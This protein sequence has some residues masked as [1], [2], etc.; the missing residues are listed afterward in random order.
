[1]KKRFSVILYSILLLA[2]ATV[3][4]MT[5]CSQL[6]LAAPENVTYN[7]TTISWNAVENA[8]SYTVRINEGD[9]Y[10][11]TEPRYPY[12]ASG[13]EFSVTITAVSDASKIIKSGETKLTFRPLDSIGDIRFSEDGSAAWDVVNLA[14]GYLVKIDGVVINKVIATPAYSEI[15]A[16][17]HSIQVRPV[18]T[19]DNSYYSAWSDAKSITILDTLTK[20]DISYSEGFIKWKY[21]TGAFC[22]EVSVNGNVLTSD[23]RATQ[24]AYDHENNDFEVRIKAIGNRTTTYDGKVSESKAFVFL[25]TVT[26]IFVEDG[27]LNWNEISGA[28]GYKLKLNGT[29]YTSILRENSFDKLTANVTTDIQILPIS[30]DTTYFSDWSAVKSV[31]LLPAP[32]LQWNSDYELDGAANSNVYWNGGGSAS[33]YAV[34]LT[35]PDGTVKITTYGNTQRYF[36]DAYSQVGTYTVEVKALASTTDTN[37]YDSV[38]SMPITVTRLAA[39]KAAG[40]NFIVSNPASVSEGFTV[41]FAKVSGATQYRLYKDDS[42]SQTSNTNQFVVSDVVR[43]DIIEEQ[44]INYKIQSVGTVNTVNGKITATL[45]SLSSESL[46][47][48]ISV[49]A[50]PAN[51]TMSGYTYTY[52]AVDRNQ[53]YVV[54]VGGQSYSG[55]GTSYDLSVLE[56]GIYSVSV[57]AK[58]NGSNILASNYT[59]AISVCRLDA[60]ANVKIETSDASEGILTYDDVDNAKGYYIVF[61]NDGNAIPVT[62][63][64]NINQYITEK[65]TTVYMQSSANYFNDN[66]T[67]Y[68]MTSRPGATVNF[69]KLAQPT[70]GDV[71]FTDTQLIWRHSDNINT[72]VYT[73]TY[74]VYYAN[75]TV[76]NGEKNGTTLDISQLEGGRSYTFYVKAIGNSTNYINSALS[77]PVTIYKL[78]SPTVERQNGKYVWNGVVNAVSYSVYVDG[79]LVSTL[80]HQPGQ[81]YSFTPAFRELKTYTVNVYAIGDGGYTSIRSDATT[82][83]QATKQLTT[84]DFALS[85]SD[86]SYS[87]TGTIELTITAETS[88]AAGYSYTIGGITEISSETTYSHVPSSVGTFTA[89]VFALGGNF[90]ADGIYCLDSQ[91]RGG[92]ANYA[93]TL[94]ATPNGSTMT[95][96]ADGYLSWTAISG[97]IGYEI[98]ISVDGGEYGNIQTISTPNHMIANF[99]EISVLKVRIRAKGNGDNIISSE[100]VEKTWNLK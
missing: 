2:A 59:P 90:D 11:V 49:L 32:V 18:V 23:C 91:S 52:G 63:M 46:S 7:G 89:R 74:E 26:N 92:N 79:E 39:P 57:C 9:V 37:I 82:I 95:L 58:G 8:S 88:D 94:L 19:E 71:S 50:A 84:P 27:V 99:N 100:T 83:L 10:T 61:N 62:T 35:S 24:F 48:A 41:T 30:D 67:I 76:Y 15:E 51:P 73:P 22:Y 40:S 42:L 93:I 53:G 4:T 86:S 81:T 6:E 36:Q 20:A 98:E 87:S 25:D 12:L 69:I 44:T 77:Q 43:N 17:T 34:R 28:D 21:V 31:L 70:F 66:R 65:G 14:T 64:M 55:G 60:P 97:A 72:S 75:G 33:G 38:Y 29:V 13:S 16:G 47:F 56:A 5:G 80:T 54:D 3:M 85:Y 1:M 78:A 45:S 96:T 68:Y